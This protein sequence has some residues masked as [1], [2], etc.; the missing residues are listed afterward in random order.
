MCITNPSRCPPPRPRSFAAGFWARMGGMRLRDTAW[1]DNA[2]SVQFATTGD[3]VRSPGASYLEN[4][5]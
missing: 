4:G 1:A 5:L 2:E 3:H